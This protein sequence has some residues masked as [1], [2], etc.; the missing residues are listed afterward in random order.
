MRM[1]EA[2]NRALPSGCGGLR[3]ARGVLLPLASLCLA[4]GPLGAQAEPEPDPPPTFLLV[5]AV[6]DFASQEPVEGARVRV[7]ELQ[8][9]AV[10][11]AEGIF[12]LDGLPPGSYTFETSRL[13]YVTI[14][15][16]STVESGDVLI[17]NLLPDP[18][19]LEGITATVSRMSRRRAAVPSAVRSFDRTALSRSAAPSIAQFL[20]ERAGLRLVPCEGAAGDIVR[21]DEETRP[22]PIESGWVCDGSRG[23]PSRLQLYVDEMPSP[24]QIDWLEIWNPSDFEQAEY[25]PSLRMVRLYTQAFMERLARGQATLGP[26]WI[27]S[28]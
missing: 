12:Y 14:S 21:L 8:R 10:T 26:I 2:S 17:V 16:I 5:G 7:E 13:G 23:R 6:L 24:H 20:S 25:Y 4:A 22:P 11:D 27:F 3:A 28:R 9:I 18:I 1:P 15:E 19:V